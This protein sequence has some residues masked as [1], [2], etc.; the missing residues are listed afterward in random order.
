MKSDRRF[1]QSIGVAVIYYSITLFHLGCQPLNAPNEMKFSMFNPVCKVDTLINNNK[2][3][4]YK[5]NAYLV[6]GFQ[7]T[8]VHEAQID[9]F[10]CTIQ[11][12]TWE[13]FSECHILIYKESKYTN[14]EYITRNPRDLD[15]YSQENDFLYWYIWSNGVFYSKVSMQGK[16]YYDEIMCHRSS[17]P[18][19]GRQKR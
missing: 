19:P 10:V 4:T 9:S 14:N 1:F 12:S 8:A 17:D 15:R 3:Y 2:A 18:L 16:P 13:R 11:D 6:T 7:N 5:T